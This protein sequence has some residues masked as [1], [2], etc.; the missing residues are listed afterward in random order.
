MNNRKPLIEWPLV[1][2]YLDYAK[3]DLG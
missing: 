3:L 2:L 1:V